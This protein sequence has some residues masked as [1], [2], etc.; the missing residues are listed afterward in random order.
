MAFAER[1]GSGWLLLQSTPATSSAWT[2][3]REKNQAHRFGRLFIRGNHRGSWGRAQT[4]REEERGNRRGMSGGRDRERKERTIPVL[5]KEQRETSATWLGCGKG[6]ANANGF[7]MDDE[8]VCS[9][10]RAP[11][12]LE[13]HA[14][15][16]G[17]LLR[18][19]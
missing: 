19:V 16:G 17:N 3:R 11:D 14:G 13:R 8:D 5:G 4:R 18:R 15:G 2:R 10:E 12:E 1:L 9:T 7:A 6:P